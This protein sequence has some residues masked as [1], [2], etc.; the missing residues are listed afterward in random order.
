MFCLRATAT[1]S[2]WTEVDA[3]TEEEAVAIAGNRELSELNA[4]P[5]ISD[6]N[7]SWHFDNDGMPCNIVVD[8]EG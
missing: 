1:V 6:D 2:C 7:E 5:F 8:D 3:D 4:S